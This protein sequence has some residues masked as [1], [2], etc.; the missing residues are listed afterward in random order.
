MLKHTR[1]IRLHIGAQVGR[2]EIEDVTAITC[3]TICPQ[4][5]LLT[6]EDNLEAITWAAKHIADE[7][8]PFAL[9]ACRKQSGQDRFQSS[10][11]IGP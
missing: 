8:F 7:E 10:N 9:L 6:I 4:P 1:K 5:G 3:R 2:N 11:E